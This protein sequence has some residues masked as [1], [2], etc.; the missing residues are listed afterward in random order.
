MFYQRYYFIEGVIYLLRNKSV[1]FFEDYL[2][3]SEWRANIGFVATKLVSL[4]TE[5]ND[6]NINTFTKHFNIDRI[7]FKDNKLIALNLII[8][9]D[10]NGSP[11][12]VTSKREW[13][14]RYPKSREDH[15]KTRL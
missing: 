3:E 4:I 2:Q 12:D 15:L 5:E 6:L 11:I 8:A 13:D 9:I 10:R 7:H 14:L 1:E